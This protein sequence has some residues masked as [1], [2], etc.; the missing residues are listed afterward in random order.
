[1]GRKRKNNRGVATEQAPSTVEQSRVIVSPQVKA[2]VPSE[3]IHHED[4]ELE[5]PNKTVRV[6]VLCKDL[7]EGK[8][9]VLENCFVEEECNSW[10]QIGEKV[11]Y[12]EAKH[13]ATAGY[14]LRDNG[15][16][17]IHSDYIASYLWLRL[18]EL[19]PKTYGNCTAYG[20]SPNIRLYRYHVGQR[21]GKHIDE[22]CKDESSGAWSKY[23]VLL[24]LNG[25]EEECAVIDEDSLKTL[26]GGDTVFYKGSSGTKE[27]VRVVPK[28]GSV[29][30][31]EHGEECMIHE[32]ARVEKGVKF[33][34]RT[35]VL[36]V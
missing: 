6:E 19:V 27:C 28:A 33:L 11:G 36:Y 20:L 7:Y 25:T 26:V 21:F 31:H 1:M 30:L 35:D 22:S 17:A 32:G 13:A 8:I 10:I 2:L 18:K 9:F 4:V 5:S 29:L 16:L 23:T 12:A 24:Y 34:L 14:A 15:R 3:V